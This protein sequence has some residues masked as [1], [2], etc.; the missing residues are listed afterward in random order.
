MHTAR[1]VF[2]FA[3]LGLAGQAAAEETPYKHEYLNGGYF[4][5]ASDA[6]QAAAPGDGSGETQ[7]VATPYRHIYRNSSHFDDE[8]AAQAGNPESPVKTSRQGDRD[9]P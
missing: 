9:E 8:A 2:C 6:G 7:V 5:G 3:L 1:I 4:E